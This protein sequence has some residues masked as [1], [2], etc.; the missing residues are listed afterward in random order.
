MGRKPSPTEE[1]DSKGHVKGRLK[2]TSKEKLFDYEDDYQDTHII[3][4]SS[5]P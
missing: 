3:H 2:G 4:H 1:N 5:K